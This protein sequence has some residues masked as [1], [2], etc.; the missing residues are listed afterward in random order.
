[1]VLET[2]PLTTFWWRR[3]ALY[4]K[5]EMSIGSHRSREYLAPRKSSSSSWTA[6]SQRK[7]T[8]E[9]LSLKCVRKWVCLPWYL[10]LADGMGG[11]TKTACAA[12]WNF[13]LGIRTED[14]SLIKKLDCH[15][16]LMKALKLNVWSC[17]EDVILHS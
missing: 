9:E 1:M 2:I 12:G 7:A 16:L 14:S 11:V 5:T 10:L 4:L 15:A 13:I 8:L 3:N 17:S 6:G